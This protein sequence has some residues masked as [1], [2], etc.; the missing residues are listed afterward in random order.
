MK[1]LRKPRA[2]GS[3]RQRPAAEKPF[4]IFCSSPTEKGGSEELSLCIFL[5]MRKAGIGLQPSQSRR[6]AREV[7]EMR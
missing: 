4:C 2:P 3:G 6:R 1:K 7:A 5:P